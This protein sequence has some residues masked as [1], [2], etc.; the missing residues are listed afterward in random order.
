MI[1]KLIIHYRQK[2]M[3]IHY[4]HKVSRS[5]LLHLALFIVEFSHLPV[6]PFTSFHYSFQIDYIVKIALYP[7]DL[8]YEGF[9]LFIAEYTSDSSSSCLFKSDFFTF[10]IIKTEI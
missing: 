5:G 8:A 4:L 1:S 6:K 3:I 9:Y 10:G 2:I 7:G